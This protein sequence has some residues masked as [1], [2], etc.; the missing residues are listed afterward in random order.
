MS[1]TT[2]PSADR[3]TD[4]T[5]DRAAAR[6]ATEHGHQAVPGSAR[7][8]DG[9]FFWAEAG[10]GADRLVMATLANHALGAAG[11]V[12]EAL[13]PETH[14]SGGWTVFRAG[15]A[16]ATDAALR[17][18]LPNLVP[19]PLGLAT[20]GGFGDRLGLATPGHVDALNACGAAG[21]VEAIFGQ[22][23]MRENARTGRTPRE[24]VDDATWGAFT[25][26][27]Q[28]AVGADADHLK[29]EADIDLCLAVGYSFFTIDPGEHVNPAA[30]TLS[31]AALQQAFEALPWQAMETTPG[32]LRAR[33]ADARVDLGA[34]A[35][36][37]GPG[38]LE[39]AA[40]K[41]GRAV[42]HVAK[43][44]RHL[45]AT[46]T[47]PTELEVS[48]DETPTPT[49]FAEHVYLA[50]ELRRLGVAWVSLAPRFVGDF[51][52]GVEYIGDLGDL[53]RCLQGHAAIAAQLGPYKLSLHSGSDKFAVY[54][55]A[56]AATNG[57]VHLKT[58]GTSYLEALRVVGAHEPGLLRRIAVLAREHFAEDVHSYH[59]SGN[60]A[61]MPD[62]ATLEGT[63]VCALLE[64]LD[65]RQ[66]LHV[67]FGS[68]LRA[69]GDE[70][71]A[72][73]LRE[74]AAYRAALRRH[75]ERHIAPLVPTA[76]GAA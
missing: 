75:F 17:T 22:Q 73:L 54:P 1:E 40:V 10:G 42:A 11:A 32:D 36:T 74:P 14:A 13:R 49:T 15:R 56:A 26:G 29:S 53:A 64:Q 67:T 45:A 65:A 5:A 43:L 24:V 48:V 52:K 39:R 71:R 4:G 63:A 50:T 33:L 69:H 76:R 58:A 35:A 70:I 72:V 68:A 8:V 44:A 16:P 18:L 47:Y 61:R 60:P 38:A 7:G 37:F 59:I 9:L 51:E 6:V 3:T 27:W 31:G 41:Y 25:A 46:A 20:S 66:V 2:R 34:E 30:D 62:L 12:I 19:R 28:H 57:L 23:S 55:I 21:K